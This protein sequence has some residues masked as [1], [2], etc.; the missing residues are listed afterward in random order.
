MHDEALS[1]TQG[2]AGDAPAHERG[3]RVDDEADLALDEELVALHV[4]LLHGA[5]LGRGAVGRRLDQL[6][7][8]HRANLQWQ[9]H[10]TTRKTTEKKT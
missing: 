9:M 4:L 6:R 2:A 5:R 7:G 1:A 8:P 3:A 10:K